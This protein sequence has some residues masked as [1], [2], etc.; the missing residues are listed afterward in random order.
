MHMQQH[1]YQNTIVKLT[2]AKEVADLIMSLFSLVINVSHIKSA[3]LSRG[4]K[5]SIQTQPVANKIWIRLDP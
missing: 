5:M 3:F 1:I 4:N 2:V